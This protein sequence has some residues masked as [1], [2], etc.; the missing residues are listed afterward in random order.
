MT[1]KS[2]IKE[3]ELF[4]ELSDQEVS[5]VTGGISI[6]DDKLVQYPNLGGCP[7]CLSGI[8]PFK[9]NHLEI[10]TQPPINLDVQ[11]TRSL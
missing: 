10:I 6:Q 5:T 11:Q 2:L 9:P 4:Q 3:L 8:P 7:A 1:D